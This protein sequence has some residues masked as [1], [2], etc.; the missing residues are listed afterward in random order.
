MAATA[1]ALIL[2]PKKDT[3]RFLEDSSNKESRVKDREL[4]KR[5]TG[6]DHDKYWNMFSW[7]MEHISRC[8]QLKSDHLTFHDSFPGALSESSSSP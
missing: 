7:C 4:P 3:R 6:D 2:C 1:R 5:V 8:I